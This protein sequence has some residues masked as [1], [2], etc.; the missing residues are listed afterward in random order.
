MIVADDSALNSPEDADMAAAKIAAIISPTSPT[1]RWV[2]MKVGKHVV[3]VGIALVAG[4]LLHDRDRPRA[5]VLQVLVAGE[6]LLAILGDAGLTPLRHR[7][8]ELAL[9]R[10]VLTA[11][12]VRPRSARRRRG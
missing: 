5:N 2:V 7:R 3:D 8:V 1:G 12:A 6:E 11:L 4:R 9:K 10:G